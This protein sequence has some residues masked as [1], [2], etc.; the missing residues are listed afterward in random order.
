[1]STGALNS[2]VPLASVSQTEMIGEHHQDPAG[3][4]L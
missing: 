3:G 1:M 4:L 2:S